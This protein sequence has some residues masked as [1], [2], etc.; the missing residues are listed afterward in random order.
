MI[1]R[2]K[3]SRIKSDADKNYGGG[4]IATP[5]IKLR[6]KPIILDENNFQPRIVDTGD[7]LTFEPQRS[8]NGHDQHVLEQFKELQYQ[9]EDLEAAYKLM[10]VQNVD[11]K[12]KAKR[13]EKKCNAQTQELNLFRS[14]N[15]E[16]SSELI[17]TRKHYD[18]LMNTHRER[19]EEMA[20]FRRVAK[21]FDMELDVEA[22]EE[23]LV[24]MNDYEKFLEDAKSIWNEK[25]SS[26][27]KKIVDLKGEVNVLKNKTRSSALPFIRSKTQKTHQRTNETHL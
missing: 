15:K 18:R 27:K 23:I 26:Y 20:A 4:R 10:A 2:I 17:A 21:K 8:P 13:L 12:Q 25:R 7:I 1:K 14:S 22:F 5:T 6:R 11:F 3:P 19:K 16:L 9:Y 24:F